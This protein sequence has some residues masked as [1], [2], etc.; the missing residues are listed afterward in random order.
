MITSKCIKIVNFL[1][2]NKVIV[3]N[4]IER[5]YTLLLCIK[6][7]IIIIKMRNLNKTILYKLA[8]TK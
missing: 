3:L 6:I 5:I 8:I 2:F 1:G 7:N 4:N